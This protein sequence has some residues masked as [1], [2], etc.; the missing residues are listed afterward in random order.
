VA[1]LRLDAPN[2][3]NVGASRWREGGRGGALLRRC[4]SA[5]RSGGSRLPL[6]SSL[7]RE[8]EVL[9]PTTGGL[10]LEALPIGDP[11]RERDDLLD[12]PAGAVDLDPVLA[13]GLG[14]VASEPRAHQLRGQFEGLAVQCEAH[15]Y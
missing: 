1:E 10:R 3:H 9:E 12:R 13:D 4:L 6:S 15:A 14:Y 2:E 8:A 5:L 11:G 7:D